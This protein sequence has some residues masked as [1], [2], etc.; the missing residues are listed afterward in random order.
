MKVDA[1]TA[2][3]WLQ[4]AATFRNIAEELLH[5]VD[6]GSLCVTPDDD[7]SAD[8]RLS[9]HDYIAAVRSLVRKTKDRY[10]HKDDD[11]N[12]VD[13]SGNVVVPAQGEGE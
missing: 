9:A 1:D 11:G 4:D 7:V 13:E 3:V 8:H 10:L 12:L 2:R 6:R 5:H